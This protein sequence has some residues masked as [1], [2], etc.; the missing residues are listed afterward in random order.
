VSSAP[1]LYSPLLGVVGHGFGGHVLPLLLP[2]LVFLV[3]PS[4]W[5]GLVLAE[6]V[7]VF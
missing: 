2:G 3:S 7:V 6:I 1:C 5:C 4:L